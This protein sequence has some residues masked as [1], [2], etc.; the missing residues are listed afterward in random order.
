[1]TCSKPVAGRL[2]LCMFGKRLILDWSQASSTEWG[3]GEEP[4]VV[5]LGEQN[6]STDASNPVHPTERHKYKVSSGAALNGFPP[7][8]PSPDGG[9]GSQERS[10]SQ[11]K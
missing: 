9:R 8:I 6:M 3:Q 11:E 5:A 2:Q 1:M 4:A 10:S 7:T